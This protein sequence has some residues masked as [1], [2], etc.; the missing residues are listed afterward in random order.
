MASVASGN[1]SPD[2]EIAP[3]E[4]VRGQI[5]FQVPATATG[6]TFVFDA[7]VW[8]TGKASVALP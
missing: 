2:G 3:G 7:D 1:S 4:T 8:G 5:G 6:L